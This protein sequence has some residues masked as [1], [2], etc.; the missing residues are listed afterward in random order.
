MIE[1]VK[2]IKKNRLPKRLPMTLAKK[3]AAVMPYLSKVIKTARKKVSRAIN[4]S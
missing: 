1:K 3:V 2:I 4:N